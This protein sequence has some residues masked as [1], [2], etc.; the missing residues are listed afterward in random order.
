MLF[1]EPCVAVTYILD[2]YESQWKINF[3]L[4]V[5]LTNLKAP[6]RRGVGQAASYRDRHAVCALWSSAW[7]VGWRGK[8]TQQVLAGQSARVGW[9]PTLNWALLVFWGL[10]DV[11]QEVPADLEFFL[12]SAREQLFPARRGDVIGSVYKNNDG[13]VQC[14]SG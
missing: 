11:R 4:W 3:L 5:K 8:R 2:M 9:E 14:S 6:P 10:H 1:H 12:S 7:W 13:T